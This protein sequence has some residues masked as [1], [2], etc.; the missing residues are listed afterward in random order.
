MLRNNS[1]G[2]QLWIIT[3]C[4]INISSK[5][6]AAEQF[7]TDGDFASTRVFPGVPFD[8]ESSKE[9]QS[10]VPSLSTYQDVEMFGNKGTNG[11][12]LTW[13]LLD[14]YLRHLEKLFQRKT[15]NDYEE[16]SNNGLMLYAQ[17]ILPP[18][19]M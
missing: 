10:K 18:K 8:S 14:T 13:S 11:C 17:S 19:L 7:D 16:T 2:K 3:L 5:A 4:Q 12:K 15:K 6:H 9:N 1:I